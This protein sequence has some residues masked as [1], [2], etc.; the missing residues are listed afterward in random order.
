MIVDVLYLTSVKA[1]PMKRPARLNP[2]ANPEGV[3][4]Q[5]VPVVLM[6][7]G[8]TQKLKIIVPILQLA[9]RVYE[10]LLNLYILLDGIGL[11]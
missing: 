11:R 6:S 8:I 2:R 4:L 7:L 5:S 1:I 10:Q 9:L 3:K